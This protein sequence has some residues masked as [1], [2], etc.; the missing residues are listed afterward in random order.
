MCLATI[1]AWH[2]ENVQSVVAQDAADSTQRTAWNDMSRSMPAMEPVGSVVDLFC[3]VGGLSH[4]FRLEGFSIACGYDID[5]DC[6]FPF[7]QNNCAPFVNCDVARIDAAE[8][9]QRFDPRLP[10][11][12]AGCAPCQPFSSYSR[13]RGKPQ[14]SL[15]KDF[16]RLAAAVE[17]DIV[18]MENVPQLVRFQGGEGFSKFVETLRECGYS[19]KH[20]IVQ[21]TDFGIPQSR[22]RLVLIASKLGEPILPNATHGPSDCPTVRDVIGDLP[23]LGA[24]HVDSDDP[25][26][27]TSIM[28]DLNL[29]RI[30]ASRPGGTWR[31]WPQDLVAE[32]H[33]KDAGRQYFA[34][35]GRM[36]WD[37]PAPT[38]TT[39]FHGFGNGRFG[40]PE[41]DRALSIREGA[42]LQTFPRDF[43]FVPRGKS[44]R[45]TALGRMIGNA[46]PVTLGRV[47]AHSIKAHLTGDS[48]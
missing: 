13:G 36:E 34:V 18:T 16:A 17:P 4:G 47:I 27:R 15:L 35:Y 26:H 3:G 1:G 41:Q 44:I 38:I 7:E 46:V 25:I 5:E 9:A 2:N 10:K 19:V 24:G 6:R 43:V 12:L 39:Q 11:I 30:R 40:H 32:C 29:R 20:Q 45:I 48:S 28:S 33:R 14:W 21:C 8:V 31:D 37:Q 23:A 22:S 42:L